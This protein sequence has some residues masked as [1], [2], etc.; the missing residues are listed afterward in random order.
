VPEQPII[1]QVKIDMDRLRGRLFGLIEACGLP[2]RQEAALKACVR[3]TTYD[4]Q[5]DLEAALRAWKAPGNG[6]QS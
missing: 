3:N 2:E 4:S 1:E 6:R 5:A